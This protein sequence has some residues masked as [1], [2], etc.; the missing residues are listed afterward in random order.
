MAEPVLRPKD[1]A[2]QKLFR[3]LRQDPETFHAL[4]LSRREAS[5]IATVLE[6]Y[7]AQNQRQRNAMEAWKRRIEKV[8]G[9]TGVV[10]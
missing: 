9:E 8:L 6:T 3:F 1:A 4:I 2:Q 5:E 10:G 7:Q